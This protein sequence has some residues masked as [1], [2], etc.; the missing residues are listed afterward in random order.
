MILRVWSLS[1]S[2]EPFE[3]GALCE[4]SQSGKPQ[5]F[6]GLGIFCRGQSMLSRSGGPVPLKADDD[7]LREQSCSRKGKGPKRAVN[8]Q[9]TQ[10][11]H[12]KMGGHLRNMPLKLETFSKDGCMRPWIR[13]YI[14]L[15]ASTRQAVMVSKTALTRA[16]RQ[17]NRPWPILRVSTLQLSERCW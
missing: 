15:C 5:T 16:R 7:S 10:H 12:T 6:P 9:G 8:E 3:H 2:K 14:R 4:S 11:T 13:R 1:L 17:K